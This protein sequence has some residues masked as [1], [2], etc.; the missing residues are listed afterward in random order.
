[1][2]FQLGASKI[3]PPEGDCPRE[4]GRTLINLH[5]PVGSTLVP[6][7]TD[8]PSLYVVELMIHQW[9][10]GLTT[11][12]GVR[13]VVCSRHGVILFGSLIWVSVYPSRRR[14]RQETI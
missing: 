10:Y 11:E 4:H 9:F 3:G 5:D 6:Q 7:R 12:P 8:E 13:R 14:L 1:M 2:L